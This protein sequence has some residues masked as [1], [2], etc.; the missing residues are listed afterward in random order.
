MSAH[1]NTHPSLP[2]DQ[3][4][5]APLSTI[6]WSKLEANDPA[7]TQRLLD[8]C[9]QEGFFYL[10]LQGTQLV[11][12]E[13]TLLD[14]MKNYFHQPHEVKMED[15]SESVTDGCAFYLF[16]LPTYKLSDT[17]DSRLSA[18]TLERAS[19]LGTAARLALQISYQNLIEKSPEV[20][21]TINKNYELVSNWVF[22]SQ[23]ITKTILSRLSDAFEL[24]GSAR[25]EN[26]HREEK[27]STTTLVML[28]YPQNSNA[29][30]GGLN[31]HTD[32]GS[33]TLLFTPQWG[34][35]VWSPTKK[36]REW[37]WVEPRP[38]HAIVNVGDTLRFL[39]G[40][41]LM[42]CVHRVL[43]TSGQNQE[44]DRYSIAYLIRAES[45]VTFKDSRRTITTA[46]CCLEGCRRFW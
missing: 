34:L 40:K 30:C 38:G 9:M 36:D 6:S 28:H 18:G 33:L 1:Y 31:P 8:A 15:H 41:R 42:S 26:N 7:E 29:D 43:P 11:A 23:S 12:K 2:L 21:G 27:E 37:L 5:L 24:Q 19:T 35:Q 44:E 20:P 13:Y 25:F 4:E 45:D 17:A 46:R 14:M 39:S 16:C 10:N 3:L 32:V 22:N